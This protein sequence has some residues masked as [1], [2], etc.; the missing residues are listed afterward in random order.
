MDRSASRAPKYPC[1]TQLMTRGTYYDVGYNVGLNFS[2]Q[3]KLFFAESDNIQDRLLPFYDSRAGRDYYEESLRVSQDC[4]PQYVREVRGMADGA[5]IPFEHVFMANVSKEVYNVLFPKT[6][7]NSAD[8]ATQESQNHQPKVDRRPGM[9]SEAASEQAG[10]ASQTTPPFQE[11]Y[12][13]SDVFLNRPDFQLV[14]HNEDCDPMI[15]PYGYLLSV[16]V[17]EDGEEGEGKVKEQ[18]TSFTYP[19]FLPGCAWSYNVHGLTISINGLYP[20]HIVRESPSRIFVNRSLLRARD[21]QD[22]VRMAKNAPYGIAYGFC[23]NIS[24]REGKMAAVEVGPGK[25][26]SQV[27]VQDVPQ[28]SDPD[29]PCHYYHFNSYKH[30]KE[31]SE[32]KGLLSSTRRGQR[33]DELPP[34]RT[35]QE[36]LTVMADTH[37]LLGPIFRTPRPTDLGETVNTALFDVTARQVLVYKGREDLSDTPFAKLPMHQ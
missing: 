7:K 32:I 3:I 24:T 1:L 37:D 33:A 10:A 5:G 6:E 14:I 25:P 21:I 35:Q 31:V 36:A 18:F 30:L 11:N 19:G 20:D 8:N 23:A 16:E 15:K 4:F 26:E 34:P 28:Q 22:A 9:P 13:C 12:G 29:A 17:E 2:R 27:H